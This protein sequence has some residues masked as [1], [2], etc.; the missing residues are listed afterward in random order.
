LLFF[1]LYRSRTI[2]NLFRAGIWGLL[3]SATW[4]LKNAILLHDPSAPVFWNRPG[5]ETLW[6]D[7]AAWLKAELSI[8][9]ML[10]RLP[11]LL[12][13]MAPAL[14]PLLLT[15]ALAAA[16]HRRSRGL[17]VL[18]TLSFLLWAPMGALPRFFAPVAILWLVIASTLRY[19]DLGR[20]AAM[21]SIFLSLGLGLAIQLNWIKNIDA[22]S[23]LRMDFR[24]AAFSVAPNPP[25]EAYAELN[26]LLPEKSR[27]LLVAESR[28]FGFPRPFISPSQHDP[29]P[30]RNLTESEMTPEEIR[31]RLRKEGFTHLL[32]N[33]GEFQRL[34]NS[35]PVAPWVTP[36]GEGK[37][38]AFIQKLGAPLQMD[39][40]VR[41]W[42]LSPPKTPVTATRDDLS[43]ISRQPPD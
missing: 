35:Y 23:L 1:T 38:W 15:G 18:A 24:S 20:V 32:I 11:V 7:G 43:G 19:P 5:M 36:A 26:R 16:F 4:W 25:F 28:G 2:Q 12:A 31:N 9:E 14:F 27:V 40:P 33:M 29:S 34:K 30:L 3:G 37:W 21:L 22:F 42:E 39:G 10:T 17:C 41:I 8:H 6:R 13:P